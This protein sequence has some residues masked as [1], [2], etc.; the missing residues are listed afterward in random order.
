MLAT[1]AGLN[2]LLFLLQPL[3]VLMKPTRQ[4]VCAVEKS[5]LLKGTRYIMVSGIL[6]CEIFNYKNNL[7]EIKKK[8]VLTLSR[9]FNV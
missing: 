2:R 9:V 8:N 3:T 4:E 5:K 1:S 6:S 7:I